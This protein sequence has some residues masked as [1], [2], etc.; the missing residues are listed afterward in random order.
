MIT[1]KQLEEIMARCNATTVAPWVAF[2]EGRDCESGSSFI[3][4]GITDGENI[5]GPSRGNDLEI[6]GATNA[7]LD[8]IAH[9]RQDIPILVSEIKRLRRIIV[10][11]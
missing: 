10:E 11:Q 5:W 8:F 4:T 2:I 7:D 6:S 3:M 1:D 9:A